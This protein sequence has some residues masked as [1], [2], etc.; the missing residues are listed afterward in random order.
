M[1]NSSSKTLLV[2]QIE[3]EFINFMVHQELLKLGK[4]HFKDLGIKLDNTFY[5]EWFVC[6]QCLYWYRIDEIDKHPEFFQGSTFDGYNSI[7]T[8][9]HREVLRKNI[10]TCIAKL[11]NYLDKGKERENLKELVK[12]YKIIELL[13]KYTDIINNKYR[14][15]ESIRQTSKDIFYHENKH[16]VYKNYIFDID[17]RIQHLID[18]TTV[19]KVL[20]MLL[21]YSG[22]GIDAMHCSLPYEVYE[23]FYKKFNVRGEGYSS[24]L[25]S[26]LIEFKDTKICTAF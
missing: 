14:F 24:P 21:R 7:N 4:N 16:I 1:D 13:D 11:I 23:Y 10:M 20:R 17:K 6:I 15:I 12:E 8:W 5:K 25:N 3:Y 26:K 18:K 22:L 19:D 9:E 2:S